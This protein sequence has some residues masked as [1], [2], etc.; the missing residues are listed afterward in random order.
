[1]KH[2]SC[3]QWVHNL[4]KIQTIK[5][6]FREPHSKG[7][8]RTKFWMLKAFLTI[9]WL[10][11][12]WRSCSNVDSDFVGTGWGEILHFQWAP[13]WYLCCWSM[14]HTEFSSVTQLCPSLCHPMDCSTPGLPVLHQLLELAQ[15]H[16]HQVSDATQPSHPLSSPS[17]L[18]SNLSQH[19]GLF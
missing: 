4:A 2:D 5:K 11:I 14:D 19:Q 8:G 16:V 18:A 7:L 3:P 17:P 10:Q 15:T 6:K 9:I 1:M 13:M 12:I